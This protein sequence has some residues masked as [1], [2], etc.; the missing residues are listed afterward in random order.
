MVVGNA[1]MEVRKQA[2]GTISDELLK[3]LKNYLG[4]EAAQNDIH[5]L[6]K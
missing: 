1:M 5:S 4:I 6:S 2:R 3:N